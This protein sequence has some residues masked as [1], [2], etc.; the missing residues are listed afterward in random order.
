MAKDFLSDDEMGA[1]EKAGKAKAQGKDFI[2]DDEMSQLDPP[3][4]QEEGDKTSA[5]DAAISH[6]GNVGGYLPQATGR[7]RQAFGFLS[8]MAQGVPYDLAGEDDY[9]ALRDEQIRDLV[10][11][12]AEH[13]IASGLGGLGQA[14]VSGLATGGLLGK[15]TSVLGKLGKNVGSGAIAGLLANPGDD[16]GKT[17]GL[18]VGERLGRAKT[19]GL[20]G[21]L[22]SVG[23]GAASLASKAPGA[24][25][26]AMGKAAAGPVGG[27]VASGLQKMPAVVPV[28][29]IFSDAAGAA[30]SSSA[31]GA[32]AGY[33]MPPNNDPRD[34]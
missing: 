7:A 16:P 5:L 11:Q 33:L 24:V 20:L 3:P 27:M 8:D 13:P 4:I 6:F 29:N 12:E 28:L 26:S 19:G 9:T 17:A 32:M 30:A 14:V 2:S 1:F 34:Q 15:G 18:Q 21:G 25:L 10:T 23:T 22:A 31:P